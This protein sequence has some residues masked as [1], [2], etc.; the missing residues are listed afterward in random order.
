MSE[1]Y[2]F[3]EIKETCEEIIKNEVYNLLKA[4]EYLEK[5][6]YEIEINVGL[7]PPGNYNVVM[8]FEVN[9]KVYG[10][11]IVIKIV[12]KKKNEIN[13]IINDVDNN[14]MSLVQKFRDEYDL[15]IDDYSD[16]KLLNMLKE[17][18]FDFTQTFSDL[19][20]NS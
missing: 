20:N 16:E 4:Q 9:G 19:F 2:L 7:F 10:S 15:S 8:W 17:N 5:E 11:Q 3:K 6:N 12:I 14:E 18:Q 13:N 1:K